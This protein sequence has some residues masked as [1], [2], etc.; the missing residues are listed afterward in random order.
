MIKLYATLLA[1]ITLGMPAAN[2]TDFTIPTTTTSGW[3]T[4]RYPTNGFTSTVLAGQNALEFTVSSAD[5]LNSRPYPYNK[6]FYN[7][8]GA[9]QL[10]HTG[11]VL[12]P[13]TLTG[14]V[15]VTA[16]MLAGTTPMSTS[17]WAETGVNQGYYIMDFLSG[18]SARSYGAAADPGFSTVEIYNDI[19]RS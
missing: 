12:G 18:M 9:S 19:S 14:D 1:A 5:D 13:W 11:N 10:L 8:Q 3:T 6:T 7:T 4:D 16:N 17:L 2:A 15:Y